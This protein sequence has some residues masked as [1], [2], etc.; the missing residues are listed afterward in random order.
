[1]ALDAADAASGGAVL[2]SFRHDRLLARVRAAVDVSAV[3]EASAAA[4]ELARLAN[5][6]GAGA[7][8]R[9][10]ADSAAAILL[11][12]RGRPEAAARHFD[13]AA[14][15]WSRAPRRVLA[16]EAW[17]DAADAWLAAG[18]VNDAR[19]AAGHSAATAR[20]LRLGPLSRR[21]SRDSSAHR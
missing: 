16:A 10:A 17:A 3:D 20:A 9:A 5:L 4:D 6:S 7:G 12:S 2:E 19:R 1:V 18:H 15:A 14:R 13:A 21:C 11:A 8:A